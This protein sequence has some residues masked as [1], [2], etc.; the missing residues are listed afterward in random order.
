[1]IS[2]RTTP[3]SIHQSD[4]N[5]M[6]SSSASTSTSDT[7]ILDLNDDCLLET[8]GYFGLNELCGIVEVS[9]RFQQVS[10]RH[11][12]SRYKNYTLGINCSY[13]SSRLEVFTDDRTKADRSE[14]CLYHKDQNQKLLSIS[15]FLRNFGMVVTCI[16][17]VARHEEIRRNENIKHNKAV[18]DLITFYC[19]V[20]LTALHFTGFYITDELVNSLRPRLQHLRKLTLWDCALSEQ[21]AKK[22]SSYSPELRELFLE[23]FP[24]LGPAPELHAYDLLRQTYPKLVLISFRGILAVQ[25][26]DI[27]EFLMLN[28]QLKSIGI[29][30]CQNVDSSIFQFIAAHA[31]GIERIEIDRISMTD[32]GTFNYSG[33]FNNLSTLKLRSSL[34]VD[35]PEDFHE[36][37]SPSVLYA[38]HAAHIQLQ[39]LH[40][41]YFR[42]KRYHPLITKFLRTEQLVDAISKFRSLKTLWL[43]FIPSLKLS[44]IIGICKKNTELSELKLLGGD[45]IIG[46]EDLIEIVTYAPKLQKLQYDIFYDTWEREEREIKKNFQSLTHSERIE[47]YLKLD[48]RTQLPRSVRIRNGERRYL[49]AVE[50]I[51]GQPGRRLV[52]WS[53]DTR[54]VFK[55]LKRPSIYVDEYIRM[56][57]IVGQRREKTRLLIELHHH[58]HIFY[59]LPKDII[60]K[61]R[62]IVRLVTFPG[63]LYHGFS[64]N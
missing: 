40:V 39:H 53:D 7:V 29:S 28:P 42:Q 3:C 23:Y 55:L 41:Y 47:L 60:R 33:K 49:D 34:Y 61:F 20:K 12:S 32:D 56:V 22:L 15:K 13:D 8:I 38:M 25:K 19:D 2:D 5:S 10:Q 59:N 16:K 50:E 57:E 1:M 14:V 35:C 36:T 58:D 6:A 30:D 4:S 45:T 31:P 51:E 21:F 63:C 18:I 26:S 11:F 46:T 44:H 48:R 9:R 43:L 52:P 54:S 27:E 64:F 17:V 62:D 37:L 24:Y